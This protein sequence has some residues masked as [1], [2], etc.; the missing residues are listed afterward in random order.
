MWRARFVL[1]YY[2]ITQKYD[3]GKT[4]SEFHPQNWRF[5]SWN[6]MIA[7]GMSKFLRVLCFLT[8]N[9]LPNFEALQRIS[10]VISKLGKNFWKFSSRKI[11]AN[12]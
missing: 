10:V 4:W 11:R 12:N 5:T 3:T 8:T 9:Y 1:G 2:N 6:F 7:K